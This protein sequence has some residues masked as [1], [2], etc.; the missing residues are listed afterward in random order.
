VEKVTG[1]VRA[2]AQEKKLS[3]VQDRTLFLYFDP[4]LDITEEI[5]KRVNQAQ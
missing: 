1:V 5:I 2:Y 4:S 3:G